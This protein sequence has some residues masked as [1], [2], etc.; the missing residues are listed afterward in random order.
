MSARTPVCEL[1]GIEHPIVEAPL[2]ADP[3]LPAAVLNAGGL[4]TLGLGWA[5]D[6]GAV[7]RETAAVHTKS[8]GSNVE[9]CRTAGRLRLSGA[10][11]ETPRV[12]QLVHRRTSIATGRIYG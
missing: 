9:G 12:V 5:D 4:G 2:S 10:G 3:R 8:V 11:E 1:L 6:A 7:V